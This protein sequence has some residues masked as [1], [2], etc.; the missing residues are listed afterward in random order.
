MVWGGIVQLQLAISFKHVK[1][2]KRSHDIDDWTVEVRASETD[3]PLRITHILGEGYEARL[4]PDT[5]IQ[6][7]IEI[8]QT[9]V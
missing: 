2:V 4:R 6:S 5:N 7:N 3:V 1:P 9:I 8:L